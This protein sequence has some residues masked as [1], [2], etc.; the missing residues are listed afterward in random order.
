MRSVTHRVRDLV[1]TAATVIMS[2]MLGMTASTA[3]AQPGTTA[4]GCQKD[5]CSII[6]I[7][8]ECTEECVNST[9][10]RNCNCKGENDCESCICG[11]CP[12]Q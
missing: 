4:G 7:D 3:L 2:A 6:C 8:G 5:I 11:Q 12:P 1:L 9:A 10:S